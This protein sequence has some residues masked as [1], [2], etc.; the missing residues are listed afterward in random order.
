MHY[1]PVEEARDLPG[2]RLVLT[3]GVPGPWG[4]FAKGILQA[5]RLPYTAAAQ[6]AGQANAELQAW[7]GQAGAPVA[8]WNDEPPCCTWESIAWL[9]ER[10]APAP[11]LIPEDPATQAVVFGL[12]RAMAGQNG[13]G[14]CRRLMILDA[15][16]Q[17]ETTRASSA[18]LARRYGH[19]PPEALRAPGRV[20]A[21]LEWF[22]AV[23]TRQE[24]AGSSYFVGHALTLADLAWAAFAIMIAPL[25]Q[26]DCPMPAYLRAAYTLREPAILAAVTPRLLAHR[27]RIY[28][29]HLSLPLDF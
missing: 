20:L 19:S 9:A 8:V 26:A 5:K 16:L 27:E 29:Q 24:A 7:T 2:L 4:E 17:Q 15:S 21:Q 11:V 14:W 22:D 6:A 23:L 28:R 25:P 12:V 18:L 1:I 13:F 3:T 10:L